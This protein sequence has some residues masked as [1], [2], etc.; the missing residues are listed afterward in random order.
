MPAECSLG[1]VDARVHT[2]KSPTVG[3]LL[4]RCVSLHTSRCLLITKRTPH[5]EDRRLAQAGLYT[6]HKTQPE[7]ES[8]SENQNLHYPTPATFPRTFCS[9]SRD[10]KWQCNI[11]H[12]RSDY[13][14]ESCLHKACPFYEQHLSPNC[15][16]K[17]M[18]V[19]R[20][21]ENLL[22]SFIDWVKLHNKI[23][24]NRN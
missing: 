24:E 13:C 11:A 5:S 8:R 9:C 20:S 3:E 21:L 6:K 12:E 15:F 10:C 22:V 2:S 1:G 16:L 19:L 14:V 17:S 18:Y 7:L 4:H 23:L